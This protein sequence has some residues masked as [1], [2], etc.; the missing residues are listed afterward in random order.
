MIRLPGF[1]NGTKTKIISAAKDA[2]DKQ[3][4][5][6]QGYQTELNTLLASMKGGTEKLTA[7]KIARF[8]ELLGLIAQMKQEIEVANA[9][10]T[11][12][13]TAQKNYLATGKGTPEQ[14]QANVT[15][16]S[17][18]TT[19]DYEA[20]KQARKDRITTLQQALDGKSQG[21]WRGRGGRC[22]GESQDSA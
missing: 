16:G 22:G 1:P 13:Y 14:V 3:I 20:V 17:E 12:H 19:G 10:I 18:T 4:T 21:R 11:A 15:L 2:G 9:G 8:N 5:E 6:L 7:D